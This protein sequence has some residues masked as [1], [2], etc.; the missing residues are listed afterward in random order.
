METPGTFQ[1]ERA[2]EHIQAPGFNLVLVPQALAPLYGTH[3]SGPF[4]APASQMPPLKSVNTE[5]G[6]RIG[7]LPGGKQERLELWVCG[8]WNH[9]WWRQGD[10][11]PLDLSVGMCPGSEGWLSVGA[12]GGGPPCRNTSAREEGWEVGEGGWVRSQ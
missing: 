1:R 7:D 3:P 5:V 2:S 6:T 11:I 9:D 12:G 4:G 10:R 8:L